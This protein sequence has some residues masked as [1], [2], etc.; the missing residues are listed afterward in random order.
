M[1]WDIEWSEHY[2]FLER[3]SEQLGTEVPALSNKPEKFIWHDEYLKAFDILS[4]CRSSGFSANPISFTEI[5]S[6]AS[7]ANVEDFERF[8]YLIQLLDKTFLEH[9]AKRMQKK[10]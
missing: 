2:D 1:T 5:V 10:K 6:Y 3:S 4:R 8:V 7:Y 9:V